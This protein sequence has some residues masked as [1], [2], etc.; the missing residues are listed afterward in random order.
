MRLG[1]YDEAVQDLTRAIRVDDPDHPRTKR[2][3][4]LYHYKERSYENPYR[5]LPE[6]VKRRPLD[7]ERSYE[8]PNRRYSAVAQTRNL[9]TYCSRGDVYVMLGKHYLAIDDYSEAIKIDPLFAPAYNS[10]ADVY[11]QLG[12]QDEAFQDYQTVIELSSNE[13][14]PQEILKNAYSKLGKDK[15]ATEIF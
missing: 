5:R 6:R 3:D 15:E 10:R 7:K 13:T 8:N 2:E 12:M 9:E 11:L 1:K 14:I 4:I